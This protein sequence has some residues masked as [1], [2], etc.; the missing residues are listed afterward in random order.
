[1]VIE[2]MKYQLNWKNVNIVK[3]GRPSKLAHLCNSEGRRG[4]G[5]PT[6]NLKDQSLN[7][8]PQYPVLDLE[9]DV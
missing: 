4:I 6:S 1:V 7:S 9:D 8:C 5:I 3:A 2:I